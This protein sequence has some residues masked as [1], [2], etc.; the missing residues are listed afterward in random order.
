MYRVV[1]SGM[2]YCRQCKKRKQI[3][4]CEHMGLFSKT[5]MGHYEKSIFCVCY[6]S[7]NVILFPIVFS[8]IKLRYQK[9]LYQNFLK[10]RPRVHKKYFVFFLFSPSRKLHS[11][12]NHPVCQ[13]SNLRHY[14]RIINHILLVGI[15]LSL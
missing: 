12:M 5:E 3:I 11:T 13:E 2:E 1:Q 7:K 15:Y 6:E 10:I 4:F 9:Y 8:K 14:S